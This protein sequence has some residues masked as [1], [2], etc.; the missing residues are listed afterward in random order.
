MALTK[1]EIKEKLMKKF[2]LT[3]TTIEHSGRTL[4]QIEALVS[5]GFVTKGSRG[6]WVEKEENLSQEGNAWI[7]NN[8]K[9][10]DRAT[11]YGDAIVSNNV[12]VF[13]NA[14]VFGSANVFGD[15]KISGN[16]KVFGDAEVFGDVIISGYAEVCGDSSVYGVAEV[17]GTAVVMG[18]AHVTGNLKL[19]KGCF[20]GHKHEDEDLKYFE[21]HPGYQLIGWENCS[22]EKIKKKLKKHSTDNCYLEYDEDGY[23]IC[24]YNHKIGEECLIQQDNK[25]GN[26]E[27][28]TMPKR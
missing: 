16:S 3:N 20:F 15:V 23:L 5:F 21:V 9:V 27:D 6:G 17:T 24:S 19:T 25:K 4:Y 12:E 28:E 10:F 7:L 11:I 26:K 2:K 8:A 18:I 13:E 14:E 22:A 1:K